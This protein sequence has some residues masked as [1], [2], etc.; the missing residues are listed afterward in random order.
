MW[1]GSW[2]AG[3]HRHPTP[4]TTTS[5]TPSPAA[6]PTSISLAAVANGVV[7]FAGPDTRGGWLLSRTGNFE[8]ILLVSVSVLRNISV[9]ASLMIKKI[10]INTTCRGATVLTIYNTLKKNTNFHFKFLD[11]RF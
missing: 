9:S 3:V 5:I 11:D 2:P 1:Q 4:T 8:N 7:N 6:S 10:K